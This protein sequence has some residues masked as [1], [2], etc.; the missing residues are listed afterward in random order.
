MKVFMVNWLAFTS[1]N[2]LPHSVHYRVEPILLTQLCRDNALPTTP[3]S[4]T[5]HRRTPITSV[6]ILR[7]VGVNAPVSEL[8][9]SIS[10]TWWAKQSV[11]YGDSVPQRNTI[12]AES[13][14]P[15]SSS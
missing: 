7:R 13:I 11:S 12:V 1:K 15:L 14:P 2:H 8:R 5:L 3:L 10:L 6:P 9:L 4:D